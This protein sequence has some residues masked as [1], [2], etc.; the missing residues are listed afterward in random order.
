VGTA[1]GGGEEASVDSLGVS[2]AKAGTEQIHKNPIATGTALESIEVGGFLVVAASNDNE[3]CLWG[4]FIA[5]TVFHGS[6]VSLLIGIPGCRG[7][8]V[9]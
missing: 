7:G 2:P 6:K 8:V 5:S 9:Q 3:N 4:F 1:I